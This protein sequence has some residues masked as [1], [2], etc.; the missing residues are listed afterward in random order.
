MLNQITLNLKECKERGAYRGFFASPNRVIRFIE[1][2][3]GKI[4]KTIRGN[5]LECVKLLL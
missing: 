3:K 2:A 1:E 5:G 4:L